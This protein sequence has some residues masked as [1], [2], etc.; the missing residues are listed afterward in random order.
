MKLINAE[1]DH[2]RINDNLYDKKGRVRRVRHDHYDM[3]ALDFE[4]AEVELEDTLRGAYHNER[5]NEP[6]RYSMRKRYHNG[7]CTVDYWDERPGGAGRDGYDIIDNQIHGLIRKYKGRK[8]DDCFA[9]LKGRVRNNPD[10]KIQACGFGSSRKKK[11]MIWR[12]Y[13]ERFLDCFEDDSWKYGRL[14]LPDYTVDEYGIIH[15]TKP[16]PQ[17]D[18]R[19][20]VEWSGEL[21]YVP[22][23]GAIK[24][25]ADELADARVDIIKYLGPKI[26]CEVIDRWEA[27]FRTKDYSERRKLLNTCFRKVDERTRRVIKHHTKEWYQKREKK[28]KY[29][30]VDRSAEFDRSL[31]IQKHKYRQ[32]EFGFHA[33]MANTQKDL[34]R[35]RLVSEINEIIDAPYKY[36]PILGYPKKE[37]LI[38][39]LHRIYDSG[40]IEK[41][42]KRPIWDPAYELHC[43]I[44]I[45]LDGKV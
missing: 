9:A 40:W 10:Y 16:K 43:Q 32:E 36:I 2:E 8:F 18:R 26:S 14:G 25:H 45:E 42:I 24:A 39:V 41:T 28:G 6:R 35:N 21:Y 1:F 27:S 31:W 30:K 20:I 5:H 29:K 7:T 11:A 15:I 12:A 3:D 38:E 4:D 37:H 13:R 34:R 17:N 22:N 19:D 23:Y 33:L 44:L